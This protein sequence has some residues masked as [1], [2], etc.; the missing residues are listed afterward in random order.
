MSLER[1]MRYVVLSSTFLRA[2][3]ADRYRMYLSDFVLLCYFREAG[4][5]VTM[6]DA[7]KVL[8]SKAG[9]GMAMHRLVDR[10]L[11]CIVLE[12]GGQ[13]F[14]VVKGVRSW[15][16]ITEK[17]ERLVAEV[18]LEL[19]SR[20]SLFISEDIEKIKAAKRLRKAR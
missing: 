14:Q 15:Y 2:Y 11:V 5:M 19:R 20:A 17:G 3:V 10:R 9:S 13:A 7:R 12:G 16:R 6:E 1:V 8:G 18:E 4:T